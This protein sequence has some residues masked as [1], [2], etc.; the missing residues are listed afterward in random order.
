MTKIKGKRLPTGRQATGARRAVA[1]IA[2]ARLK[3]L[4]LSW[5]AIA[6]GFILLIGG[7]YFYRFEGQRTPRMDPTNLKKV[8]SGKRI[9]AQACASCHGLALEGQPNWQRRLPNGRLPAPP[10]DVSGHTWHH[11]DEFLFRV[12]KYGPGAYPVGYQTD[13]PAF[14]SQLSDE[15]IAASLAFIKSTWPVEIRSKQSRM[16]SDARRPQRVP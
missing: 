13:M 10:H 12:T 5:P 14:A 16:D 6:V 11:S 2:F 15:D 7:A 1:D 8:E 9:Y 3:R 4:L